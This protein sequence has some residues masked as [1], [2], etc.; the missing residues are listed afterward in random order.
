MYASGI[1]IPALAS[2]AA[3]D[4]VAA[5]TST[6]SGGI[7]AWPMRGGKPGG[8][9]LRI[10]TGARIDNL[11]WE[12]TFAS[13][14]DGFVAAFTTLRGTNKGHRHPNSGLV[15][16]DRAGKPLGKP[17]ALSRKG[18]AQWSDF[19][20]NPVLAWDGTS[21]VA[22]WDIIL[23]EGRGL[24]SHWY[25]GVF[26]R[27]VSRDGSPQG[28]N[29]PVAGERGSPA[30]L[31]AAAS[32]GEGTTLIAYERHPKTGKTPIRIAFRMLRR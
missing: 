13:D 27:R 23:G 22:A 4:T 31:P 14:G 1:G 32:D 28:G 17:V 30:C 21:Y 12:P 6:P 7:I 8:E 3:G 29:T 16:L 5:A 10:Q 15:A 19:V 11:G 24:E 18:A 25:D 26:V 20:R 9:P 2:N